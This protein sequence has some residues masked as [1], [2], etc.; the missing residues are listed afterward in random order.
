MKSKWCRGPFHPPGGEDVPITEFSYN[1]S[2]SREGKPLSRCKK[3]R[4]LGKSKTVPDNVFMP[5]LEML[6]QGRTFT[7]A[8]KISN[9]N[10]EYL[11]SLYKGKR[12]R[13]YKKT[14]LNLNRAVASLPKEKVSIGPKNIKSNRNG[15]TKLSYEERI[16]LKSLISV[17][18]KDRYLKD[19]KLLK[20]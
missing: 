18:Q 2:G 14:F 17:A 16:A 15:R 13:I 8:E 9:I 1:K 3:C 4:S 7:E 11:R 12:K 20:Y 5:L 10:A 19:K 6:L